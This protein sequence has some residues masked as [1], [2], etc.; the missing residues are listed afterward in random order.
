VVVDDLRLHDTGRFLR[1]ATHGRGMWELDISGLTSVSVDAADVVVQ[2]LTMRV[3]GNPMTT[4]GTLR[5]A[6]RDAGHIRLALHDVSGR[7]VRVLADRYA[8]SVV[9]HL[10]VDVSDLSP[11]VYYARLSA[12]GASVSKKLVVAR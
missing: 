3:L 8:S 2:P 11:G 9:D 7:E 1:V 12:N 4:R 5:F 10:E 6:V